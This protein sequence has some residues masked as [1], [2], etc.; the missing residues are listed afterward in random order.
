MIIPNKI[1]PFNETVISKLELILRELHDEEE[2]INLYHKV[3][4][5]FTG[6]DQFL[7]AIDVLY[8]LDC[9]SIDEPTRTVKYAS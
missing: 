8:A 1:I 2:L 7:Y 6:I 9:I 3:K 5:K 4:R